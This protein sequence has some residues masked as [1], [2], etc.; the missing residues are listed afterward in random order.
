MT[1]AQLIDTLK[2]YNPSIQVKLETEEGLKD[3]YLQ[4]I[5]LIG[6]KA[7]TINPTDKEEPK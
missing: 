2:L 5:A 1:V 3:F 7:V 4:A 6:L